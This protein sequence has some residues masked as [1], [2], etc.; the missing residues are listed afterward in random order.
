V[1]NLFLPQSQLEEWAIAE[2]ADLRE[3][4]LVIAGEPA[5]YAIQQAV[6]FLS[7]ATGTD[8]RQLLGKVQ[9]QKQLEELKAEQMAESVILG[10]TAYEVVTGYL[11]KVEDAAT[12]APPS[13]PKDPASDSAML[14]DFLLTKLS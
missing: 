14:A 7:L 11:L 9:T 10:D 2:K 5:P 13:P 8:D 3:D 1:P 4:R 12:V 6:H